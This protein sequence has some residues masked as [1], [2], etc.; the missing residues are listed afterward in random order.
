M[1]VGFLLCLWGFGWGV[2]LV[3]VVVWWGLLVFGLCFGVGVGIVFIR[4][5]SDGVVAGP[6]FWGLWL[7]VLFL[8][9]VWFAGLV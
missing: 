4:C 7:L 2:V 9:V 5:G 3:L 1:F 8:F 6:G